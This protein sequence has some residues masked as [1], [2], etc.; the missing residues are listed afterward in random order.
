MD[1]FLVSEDTGSC[2]DR[3]PGGLA[4]SFFDFD[5]SSESQGWGGVGWGGSQFLQVVP[6]YKLGL[7]SRHR[8][9]T[10]CL[11]PRSPTPHPQQTIYND[12]N[13]HANRLPIHKVWIWGSFGHLWWCTLNNLTTPEAEAGGSKVQG[14]LRLL[15]KPLLQ[16]QRKRKRACKTSMKTCVCCPKSIKIHMWWCV[17]VITAQWRYW[18]RGTPMFWG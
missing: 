6:F 15:G 10:A 3:C 5:L 8:E 9:F 7:S 13:N 12:N 17:L 11:T 18:T 1:N 14:Q 2:E 4:L 16:K